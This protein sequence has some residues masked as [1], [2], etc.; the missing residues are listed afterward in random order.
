MFEVLN[1]PPHLREEL[2]AEQKS[3]EEHRRNELRRKE[4]FKELSD[5]QLESLKRVYYKDFAMFN[6]SMEGY[7][8]LQDDTI[9][10]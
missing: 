6:Y 2:T 3:A 4:Y 10:Y 5:E 8:T 1:L 7:G 9:H